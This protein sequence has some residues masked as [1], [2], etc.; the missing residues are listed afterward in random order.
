MNNEINGIWKLDPSDSKSQQLYGDVTIE[1]KESGELIYTVKTKGKEQK[2]F[3]NYELQENWILTTQPPSKEKEKTQFRI[4][5]D[6]KLELNFDGIKS[7]YI[8]M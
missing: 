3:M 6:G 8:K 5:P 1:F 2:T 4:Q 7:K